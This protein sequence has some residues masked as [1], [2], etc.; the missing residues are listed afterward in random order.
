MHIVTNSLQ[1]A[2][3]NCTKWC[4]LALQKRKKINIKMSHAF[5]LFQEQKAKWTKNSQTVSLFNDDYY[6]TK[7]LLYK[8]S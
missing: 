2:Q 1:C 5:L 4:C 3:V 7:E 6:D 8:I